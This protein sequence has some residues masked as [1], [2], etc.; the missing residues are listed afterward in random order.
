M[1]KTTRE[2]GNVSFLDFRNGNFNLLAA[3]NLKSS[4][5]SKVLV[6]ETRGKLGQKR[7]LHSLNLKLGPKRCKKKVNRF[8]Q[9][10]MIEF[11]VYF[12]TVEIRK[13][14]KHVQLNIDQIYKKNL[15]EN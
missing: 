3:G 4:F 5:S 2:S 11:C 7:H 6:S 10:C 8:Y 9:V 14:L 1:Y 12:P 13:Y 15:D